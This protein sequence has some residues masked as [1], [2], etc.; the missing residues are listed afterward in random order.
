MRKIR[1][2]ILFSAAGLIACTVSCKRDVVFPSGPHHPDHEIVV[3]YENDVHNAISGYAKFAALRSE[4]EAVTPYVTT[5]SSGDYFQGE[6]IGLLSKG[7]AIARI[8]NRVGYDYVTL[9]NHE[10]DFGLDNMWHLMSNVMDATVVDVNFC[11]YPSMELCFK[12]YSIEK[13]GD[14]KV[15]YLGITTPYAMRDAT[16]RLFLDDKGNRLYDFM[17][18]GLD[19]QVDLMARKA[20]Q[21]GA[22][23]VV[24]LSH[25]GDEE[26]EVY[27]TAVELIHNTRNID[28]VL[29]AHAH[30]IIRDSLVANAEGKMVHYTSTGKKFQNMGVMKISTDGKISTHLYETDKYDKIDAGVEESIKQIIED[31]REAGN[32]VIA[33]SDFDLTYMDGEGRIL[34]RLQECNMG[35]FLTDVLREEFCTDIALWTGGSFKSNIKAGDITFNNIIDANPFGNSTCTGVISGQNLLDALEYSYSKLPATSNTFIQVSGLKVYIDTSVTAQFIFD[36]EN[37]YAGVKADSPRRVYKLEIYNKETDRYEP[38]D[39]Q[40]EYTVASSDY[41]ILYRSGTAAFRYIKNVVDTGIID[42]EL[43]INTLVN[44][45]GSIVPSRYSHLDGRI[46]IR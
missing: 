38:V 15:A 35:D 11:H 4:F 22:D 34:S 31:Y 25:V 30:S 16:M 21:D 28:I 43:L 13:Y 44:K 17:Y 19:S 41:L 37:V 24:L 27:E 40:R 32:Y 18:G 6:S 7:E 3:M 36:N 14:V 1:L 5:V 42:S 23:Y 46:T 45:M 8:M 33:H 9:G 26:S 2:A 12:P 29:D 10:F 39:L 20:R